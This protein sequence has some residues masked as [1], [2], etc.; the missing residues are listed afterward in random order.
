[1][2]AVN[3]KTCVFNWSDMEQFGVIHLTGEADALSRRGLFDLTED[4]RKLV[5]GFLNMPDDTALRP[6]INNVG[7][8]NVALPYSMLIDLAIA[9]YAKAG[10][11]TIIHYKGFSSYVMAVP[12][13]TPKDVVDDFINDNRD[14]VT[15]VRLK[16]A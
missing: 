11:K 13:E 1:M 12:N 8:A 10:F 5:L 6:A 16:A 2:T 3:L 4:G 15:V 7:V 9:A 14:R